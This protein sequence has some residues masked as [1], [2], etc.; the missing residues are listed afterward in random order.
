MELNSLEMLELLN[1]RIIIKEIREMNMDELCDKK[2]KLMEYCS[3]KTAEVNTILSIINNSRK[4]RDYSKIVLVS[5]FYEK[6]MTCK[7][8]HYS[9]LKLLIFLILLLFVFLVY[10]ASLY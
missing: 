7:Q 8:Q 10:K 1:M 9:A 4:K 3:C 6:A 2:N 5:T